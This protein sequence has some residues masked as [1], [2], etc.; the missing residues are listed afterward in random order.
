MQ[1]PPDDNKDNEPELT[2]DVHGPSQRDIDR[3]WDGYESD[4]GREG[5]YGGSIVWKTVIVMV[6]LVILGSMALGIIGPLLG[7]SQQE[8]SLEPERVAATVLRVIDG[9]T[10][11]IDDG[12]GEQTVRLIGIKALDFRDPFFDFSREVVQ[13]WIEGKSVMLESDQLELDSQGR[14]L[15]YVFFENIM[16]N[17][18][19]MLNGLATIET[20]LPNV[21]YDDYLKQMQLQA[22]ESEVGIWDPAYGGSD[23][24]APQAFHR[25]LSISPSKRFLI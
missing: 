25:Y 15:R 18:A 7:G 10:I 20:E 19:L 11:I 2:D 8:R 3:S 21:R 12:Q 4:Q 17:A 22:R 14:L 5:I 16:I 6:S 24:N 13:S 9:R 23:L 1:N